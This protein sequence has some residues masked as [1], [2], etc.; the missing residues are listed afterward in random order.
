MGDESVSQDAEAFLLLITG[1][2]DDVRVGAHELHRAGLDGFWTF[3][4]VRRTSTG[5]PS[6]G[7]SS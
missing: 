3:G 5:F 4:L 1:P 2:L 6:E 7:P